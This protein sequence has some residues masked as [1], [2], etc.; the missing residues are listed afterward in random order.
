M[1]IA[2]TMMMVQDNDYDEGNCDDGGD[3][4]DC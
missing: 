2:I 3:D 1:Q 4:D